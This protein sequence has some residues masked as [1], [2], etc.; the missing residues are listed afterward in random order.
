VAA[1]G[2]AVPV[3][4]EEP[5]DAGGRHAEAEWWLTV[6]MASGSRGMLA[7]IDPAVAEEFARY[8]VGEGGAGAVALEHWRGGRRHAISMLAGRPGDL[9]PP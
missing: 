3:S 8:L 6:E 1:A 2:Q 7:F 4:S 5:P 9:P